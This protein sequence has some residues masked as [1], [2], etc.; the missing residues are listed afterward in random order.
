MSCAR[1]AC[2]SASNL[3]PASVLTA[4]RHLVPTMS[5]PS[6]LFERVGYVEERIFFSQALHQL[7]FTTAASSYPRRSDG[8]F[9]AKLFYDSLHIFEIFRPPS[10]AS[11]TIPILSLPTFPLPYYLRLLC[12]LCYPCLLHSGFGAFCCLQRVDFLQHLPEWKVL[13]LV[14]CFWMQ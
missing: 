1:N 4:S 6:T 14:K 2:P 9:V 12:C 3:A 11:N 5:K 7:Q 8:K 13:G 10:T